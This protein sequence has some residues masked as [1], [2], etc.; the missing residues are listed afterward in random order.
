MIIGAVVILTIIDIIAISMVVILVI[1]IMTINI[2]II[3]I[4]ML[5]HILMAVSW[6]FG[7]R[8]SIDLAQR[9]GLRG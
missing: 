3:V 6:A 8:P 1:V 4:N 5:D 2:H 9:C 7:T